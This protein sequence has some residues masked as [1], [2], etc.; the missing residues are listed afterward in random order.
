MPVIRT[1][2]LDSE[3]AAWYL[4]TTPRWVRTA[5]CQGRLPA[6]R[7]GRHLRFRADDLDSWVDSHCTV[8]RGAQVA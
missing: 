3:E 8:A 7:V 4:R 2:L 5:A 6:V 1:R